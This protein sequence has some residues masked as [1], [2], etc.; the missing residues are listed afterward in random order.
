M[1]AQP[2]SVAN[3]TTTG[4]SGATWQ[5]A[6]TEQVRHNNLLQISANL[7]QAQPEAQRPTILGSMFTYENEVFRTATSSQEYVALLNARVTFIAQKL[8]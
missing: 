4:G 7:L 6:I 8:Q 2:N 5:S 3:P 1:S